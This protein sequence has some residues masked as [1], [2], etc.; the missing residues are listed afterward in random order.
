MTP[1]GKEMAKSYDESYK[2]NFDSSSGYFAGKETLNY[3]NKEID[4]VTYCEGMDDFV[5]GTYIIEITC[6]GVVVGN[7]TLKLD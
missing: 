2:F 3:A 4:G 5:P 7:T 6:D 1:D